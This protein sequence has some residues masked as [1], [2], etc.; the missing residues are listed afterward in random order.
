MGDASNAYSP[1]KLKKFTREV[2]YLPGK[3]LLFVFDLV[4][5]V[6]PAFRKAWLLHGV[7][8]PSVDADE[9]KGTE[10]T[11]EFKNA[12]TVRFREGS[13]ELL[14]H[15][16][17]PRDRV[18][19]RRGGPGADF[20]CPG[21]EHGGGWGSGENWPLEPQEGA[22]LPEDPKLR[23]MWKTFWGR[24]LSKIQPSNRKNVVPGAWRVEVSP[25]QPAE[26]DFFLHV[27]EIGKIGIPGKRTDLIDGVNF[28]GAASESGPFVL[29]ATSGSSA[30]GGEVSLPNLACD[31]LIVS[32]LQPDT[33]YELSF[34]GPNVAVSSATA[35]PGVLIDILRLRS[36]SKGIMRLERPHCGDLHLRIARV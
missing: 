11:K 7:N 19:T 30:R 15:S 34:T 9:G 33:F 35:L 25:A 6:D 29:F 23:R 12:A 24:D 17:L 3:N 14:V 8:Q 28:V 27:F 18:V 36:N 21:D 20:F 1:D 2:V 22:E 10:T 26:K 5:S 31:S 4:V 16:L 32:G 13:G